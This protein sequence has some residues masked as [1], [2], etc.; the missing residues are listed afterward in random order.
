MYY[1]KFMKGCG[2]WMARR[3][4][5]RPVSIFNWGHLITDMVYQG[6]LEIWRKLPPREIPNAEALFTNS[7]PKLREMMR[8][9]PGGKIG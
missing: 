5:T 1:D 7:T 6:R 3:L 4:N 2:F 9:S 8:I